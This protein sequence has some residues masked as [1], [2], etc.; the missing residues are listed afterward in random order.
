MTKKRAVKRQ[1]FTF[2]KKFVEY[3]NTRLTDGK[4][5]YQSVGKTLQAGEKTLYLLH[6]IRWMNR[7]VNCKSGILAVLTEK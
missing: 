2:K 6:M 5:N 3:A 4:R 1:L 7:K